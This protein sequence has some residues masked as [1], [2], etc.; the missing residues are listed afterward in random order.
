M[1]QAYVEMMQ[2]SLEKKKA[3]LD[4]I[5]EWNLRQKA[6][7]ECVESTP[8]EFDETIE[9]KGRLIEQLELLDSGF[10][11]LFANMKEELG[12]NQQLYASKIKIM[13]ELIRDITDKSVEIQAQEARNKALMTQKFDMV[14]QQVK[15]VRTSGKVAS[16]YYNN[17]QKLNYVEPQ[18]MDNKN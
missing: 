6:V 4:N 7:L 3:I 17:M 9:A 8:E 1:E 12:Q 10:E 14:R 16:Q 18:F 11:K 5:I 15:S 2:Q 13:Q